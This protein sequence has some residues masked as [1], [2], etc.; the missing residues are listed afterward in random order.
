MTGLTVALML[1]VLALGLFAQYAIRRA[2][3]EREL[4][5]PKRVVVSMSGHEPLSRA[6]ARDDLDAA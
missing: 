4:A 5:T 2:D 1:A 3:R 6:R